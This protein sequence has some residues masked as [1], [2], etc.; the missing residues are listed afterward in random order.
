MLRF[1]RP[2][3]DLRN[4]DFTTLNLQQDLRN[5]NLQDANLSG[6]NLSGADLSY[7]NL[8]NTNF[9]GANL[10][11]ANLSQ[12][13][14][15]GANFRNANLT[16]VNFE[17]ANIARASFRGALLTGIN[18]RGVQR[19]Q[20]NAIIEEQRRGPAPQQE[21]QSYQRR[22]QNVLQLYPQVQQPAPPVPQ[23]QPAPPVPQVQG[24]A[25]EVHNLFNLLDMPRIT[26]YI[27]TFNDITPPNPNT[28]S[29][30]QSENNLFTPLLIFVDKSSLFV[31][32]EKIENKQKLE[33]ILQRLETMQNFNENYRPLLE[34]VIRFV[35][36]QNDSF[37][38]QYIRILSDECLNAYGAGN[39]SCLK[40]VFERMITTLNSVT[41]ALM[42]E[43]QFKDNQTYKDI[44]NLFNNIDFNETVQE[45]ARLYLEGGENEAELTPLTPAQRKEHF[46]NFMRR[47][48]GTLL[49]Q[50]IEQQINNEA[51]EYETS[52]VFDR[53]SFGG[54]RTKKTK[55][56][57]TKRIIK[58]KKYY[59]TMKKRKRKGKKS[60]KR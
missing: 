5:A 43:P 13:Y 40:G 47:K 2:G 46:K 55:R 22:G 50:G 58:K 44:K 35:S 38:E 28:Q 1:N 57:R 53:M 3:Q 54:K 4:F 7:S 12:V 39:Q 42:T 21:P 29:S 23:Q 31:P 10:Q 14:A 30:T 20:L 60:I 49:S 51:N 25:F 19:Q 48:Y 59:K 8:G 18:L 27:R 26:Q 36:S 15:M 32:N 16:N 33:N 37:I 52:G 17:V 45:W 24:V 11:N 41:I 56:R 34:S 6:V 9:E